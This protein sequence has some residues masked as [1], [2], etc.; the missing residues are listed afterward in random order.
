MVIFAFIGMAPWRVSTQAASISRRARGA[1]ISIIEPKS[2]AQIAR[3]GLCRHLFFS[4]LNMH[5]QRRDD[6]A[7]LDISR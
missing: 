6:D 1:R 4:H 7:F 3:R 2:P 5:G